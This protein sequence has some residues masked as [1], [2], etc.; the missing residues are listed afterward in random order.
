MVFN[1]GE[2]CHPLIIHDSCGS[3]TTSF[4][5][6]L[7]PGAAAA[8]FARLPLPPPL[9]LSS[10]AKMTMTEKTCVSRKK[11]ETET[12]R[13]SPTLVFPPKPFLFLSLSFFLLTSRTPL[14]LFPLR[15]KGK[16]CLLWNSNR[17]YS[18]TVILVHFER[19]VCGHC[20]R[21]HCGREVTRP[22]FHKRRKRQRERVAAAA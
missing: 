16:T 15:K 9:S 7:L 17:R 4:F 2:V 13:S 19:T 21:G 20:G 1:W 12:K 5:F 3:L 11:T 18:C 14:L 8:L 10:A 6:L 22:D